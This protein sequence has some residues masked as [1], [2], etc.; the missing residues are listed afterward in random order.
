MPETGDVFGLAPV[1]ELRVPA[2]AIRPMRQVAAARPRVD[3]LYAGAGRPRQSAWA[4]KIKGLT[5]LQ[6]QGY[7]TVE[8]E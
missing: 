1:C 8:A 3:C 2:T 4:P 6:E 5:K 7:D